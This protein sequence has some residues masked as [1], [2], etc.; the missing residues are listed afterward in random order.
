M[1]HDLIVIFLTAAEMVVGHGDSAIP[2]FWKE[3]IPCTKSISAENRVDSV[4]HNSFLTE[5][6][7]AQF[8]LTE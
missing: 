5:C 6:V 2:T 3:P 1:Q 7:G 4:I 8:L